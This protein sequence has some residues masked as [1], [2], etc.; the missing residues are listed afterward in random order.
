VASSSAGAEVDM[1]KNNLKTPYSDQFSNRHAQYVGE[2]NTSAAVT[3]VISKNGFVFT[4]GNRYPNGAFWL[5]ADNPGGT[6]CRDS[7]L[8]IGTNGAQ[9]KTTQV[10]LSAEKPYTTESPWVDAGVYLHRRHP[11][12][13]HYRT[14]LVRPTNIS[15]YPFIRSDAAPRHRFVTAGSIGLPWG[16]VVASKLTLATPIP[17]D[18][19]ANFGLIYPNGAK[20]SALRGHSQEFLR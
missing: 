20:Q 17:K 3:R 18:D 7:L 13:F 8:I 4:L 19:I 2:W 9:T 16:F 11:E 15:Q 14:L 5:T 6:G 12:P 10:L 1:L